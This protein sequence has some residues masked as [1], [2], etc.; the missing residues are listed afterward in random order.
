MPKVVIERK[1]GEAIAPFLR[2]FLLTQFE[3]KEIDKVETLGGII[4]ILLSTSPRGVKRKRDLI[5]DLA[6]LTDL[7]NMSHDV[8]ELE[9]ELVSLSAAQL[10]DV[11]SILRLP[12]PKSLRKRELV[13]S[14]SNH[15][16]SRETW[17][18]IIGSTDATTR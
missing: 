1:P 13:R 2:Q 17:S 6:Y 4:E 10:R 14:I 12:A 5:I 18:A 11:S 8:E 16:K 7:T 9:R 15:L 3:E